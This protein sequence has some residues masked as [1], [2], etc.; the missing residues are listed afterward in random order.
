M[1][2]GLRIGALLKEFSKDPLVRVLAQ[3]QASFDDLAAGGIAFERE[4][5]GA[6]PLKVVSRTVALE[7]MC[8]NTQDPNPQDG[9]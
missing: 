9:A 2:Q 4:P 5:D 3:Y 8:W 7:L 1:R 6:L